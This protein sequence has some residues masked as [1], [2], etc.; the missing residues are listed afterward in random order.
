[1]KYKIILRQISLITVLSILISLSFSAKLFAQD[2]DSILQS[3]D[4]TILVEQTDDDTDEAAPE[5]PS[6]EDTSSAED[7]T[8]PEPEPEPV[9]I[10]SF[11]DVKEDDWF[12]ADVTK[13]IEKQIIAGYPDGMFHPERVITN[14]E[15]VKILM[16]SIGADLSEVGDELLFG[17]HWAS[18]Y[19]TLAYNR[20]IISAEELIED[21]D[22]D[23]PITRSSM[24]KMMILS[25]EIE[26]AR[27]DDP[28]TDI[29]D[30][31]AST[32]YNE[33]L[34]RGYLLED[35]TRVYRG[36]SN[37]LRSE[38][39][40]IAVRIME[41]LED[42]YEY[43]KTA[44]LQNAAANA[45]NNEFEL[46]DLFYILNREFI[47]DFTFRSNI[48][49]EE[50]SKYYHHANVIHLEYFYSSYIHYKYYTNKHIYEIKLEYS[51]SLDELK[52]LHLAAE[53]KADIILESIITDDMTDFDK[54]KAIHD[55]L[56]LN[57]EYDYLN[58]I[59][60][61]IP[62]ESRLAYGAL[63]NK[64]AVC[65]GY[66]AAFNVL[67]NR[68]GIRSVG[69]TGYAPSSDDAH[70]WNMILIDGQIYYI[71]VTHDD[72]V[73]DKKGHISYKYFLLSEAE[74]TELGYTWD[75]SQSNLKYLY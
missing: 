69:I 3:H 27:I 30:I 17:N 26:P 5:S 42:S 18:A 43:K 12:Y 37:A 10:P 23:A 20:N 53:E 36:D 21:F 66:C 50:C 25:L 24:T 13:L 73:P 31:Y 67:C 51:P 45:L 34:L 11:P 62:L 65:Q 32:A 70:A 58:Y 40:A 46:I 63:I 75:K 71:D 22:P 52:A 49:L 60:G 48:P 47:T 68:L 74:M 14:A 7:T 61:T 35:D 57:C 64:T 33:Y 41:Y 28:F 29:S 6:S 38:A 19:I 55:Y 54:V 9:Q 59:D 39:T 8:E 44:I 4:A 56:I 16:L 1:M 15:F 2:S 72:P